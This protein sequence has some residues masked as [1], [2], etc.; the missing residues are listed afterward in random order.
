MT[1][2]LGDTVATKIGVFAEPD[3]QE[4][5]I[6]TEDKFIV[7]ATDGVWEFIS[8]EQCMNMVISF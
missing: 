7:L 3:I 2:S 1:R 6:S 5:E 8:N 4:F